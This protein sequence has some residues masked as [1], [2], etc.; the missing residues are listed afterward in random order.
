MI[1]LSTNFNSSLRAGIILVLAH[2]VGVGEQMLQLL[3]FWDPVHKIQFVRY[4]IM[5][6]KILDE[7][8]NID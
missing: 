2:A 1:D 3:V 4:L 7:I 8:I 5:E 6:E